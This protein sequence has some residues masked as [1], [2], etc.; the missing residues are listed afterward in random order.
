MPML[1][2]KRYGFV[3]IDVVGKRAFVHVAS[4]I[5][6]QQAAVAWT[7]VCELWGLVPTA[8]LND[9]GSEN[10]GKFAKLLKEMDVT[11]Y[12]ARPYTPKDKPHVERFIGTLER[13]CIQWGGL[14][15]DLADQQDIIDTW[16]VKYHDYR[17]HEALGYLT[18]KEY[19]EKLERE[20]VA[21]ML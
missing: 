16:L 10:L 1:G 4:S 14:A 9:N 21:L 5:S 11:Q 3:A 12:F 6:S 15:I 19:A 17:P 13:E 7:K 18:P 2:V 8:A 20:K